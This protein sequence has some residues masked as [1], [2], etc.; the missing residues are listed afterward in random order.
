MGKGTPKFSVIIPTFNRALDLKRCL[1]SLCSQ[2]FKDF[3]VVIC[4]DGS[5]DNTKDVV[6]TFEKLLDIN[7][8]YNKNWGGPAVPR[9]IGIEKSKGDW[10]CFLDSDDWWF[11]N[12]LEKCNLFTDD[13]DFIFH[14]VR[15][16]RKDIPGKDRLFPPG[17][18]RSFRTIYT[19][20]NFISCS[21]VCV[22]RKYLSSCFFP[23][24]KKI[25]AV[26]DYYA[27]L[28][29]FKNAKSVRVK[30]V[31]EKLSAYSMSDDNIS[32][33][34]LNY[35]HRLISLK[36]KLKRELGFNPRLG[37]VNYLIGVNLLHLGAKK[38]SKLFFKST[39]RYSSSKFIKIKSLIR[40]LR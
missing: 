2:T 37:C 18:F 10:I 12:K 17:T 22:K 24:D 38:R 9:N 26:E 36:T 20:G 19:T 40:L 6:L 21:S 14:D 27:W 15:D 35:L 4:D 3:E 39:L 33:Y 25:I 13:F 1:V 28:R 31:K 7:Y 29:L 30:H 16:Y 11:N 32:H 5:S 34:S 23:E 8:I